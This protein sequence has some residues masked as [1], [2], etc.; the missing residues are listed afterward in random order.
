[1]GGTKLAFDQDVFAIQRM[2]EN[3][4]MSRWRFLFRML[5]VFNSGEH[6]IQFLSYLN[7]AQH[8][9]ELVER[10]YDRDHVQANRENFGCETTNAVLCI[11][12]GHSCVKA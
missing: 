4:C 2:G 7:G 8:W 10:L 5:V 1:M 6:V 12:R 3:S 11:N 9:I